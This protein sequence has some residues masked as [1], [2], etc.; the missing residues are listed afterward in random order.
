MH[1]SKLPLHAWFW[2]IYLMGAHS[3]GISALQL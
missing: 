3:N 1:G 2:A